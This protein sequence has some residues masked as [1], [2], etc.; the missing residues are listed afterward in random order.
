MECV[1]LLWFLWC[2]RKYFNDCEFGISGGQDW[3]LIDYKELE[4]QYQMIYKT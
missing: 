3:I 1:A 4:K 2:L